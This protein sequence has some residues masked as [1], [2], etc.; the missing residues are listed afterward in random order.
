ME[1]T[2][3][4][5]LDA[6]VTVGIDVLDIEPDSPPKESTMAASQRTLTV[7]DDAT[8]HDVLGAA[9]STHGPRRS[10]SQRG[11][12]CL[13][14]DRFH[15]HGSASNVVVCH[16]RWGLYYVMKDGVKQPSLH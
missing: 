11:N 5:G 12:P 14:G 2:F 4:A 9:G 8:L 10:H 6:D 15:S 13:E 1:D 7:L 16:N 3:V